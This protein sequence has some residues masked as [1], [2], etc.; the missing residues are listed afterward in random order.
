MQADSAKI[1]LA[2]IGAWGH[3]GEVLK[4]T[5]KMP[6]VEIVGLAKVLPDDDF[7]KVQEKHSSAANAPLY[8]DPGQLLAEQRPTIATVSTRLDLIAG[9]AIEAANAGCHLI[10]EKPLAIT[11]EN[12]EKLWQAVETNGVQ[13]LAML[14]NRA[15]PILAAAR[16][17]IAAGEIGEVC[18]LNA[19]KS[20]RFGSRPEWF[21]RRDTYGGTIPWVGIHAL[22]FI[23]AVTGSSF[24]SVAAAHANTAHPERPECEDVCTMTLKLENGAMATVSI[25][26][27]RP[28]TAATHGD[29][30]LRIVGSKG[31]IEAGMSRG[32]CAIIT[33]DHPLRDL[34]PAAEQPYYAPRLR[35]MPPAGQGKP[36]A[37]TRRGFALTHTALR[38]REAADQEIT[39]AVNDQFTY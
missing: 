32:Q 4:E 27:L 11:T 3:F 9:L 16:K 25:D 35:A 18:L 19:R 17:A 36:D 8:D 24:S 33:G 28:A 37:E 15:H 38:A 31:V 21:G 2:V 23:E 13:C 20:Y 6:E 30:W 5:E 39:M 7:S 34:A 29:D 10:C 14:N 26:Y 1:K 12:L 22:D